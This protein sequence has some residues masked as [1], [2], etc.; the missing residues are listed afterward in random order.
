[1]VLPIVETSHLFSRRIVPTPPSGIL[2]PPNVDDL[3]FVPLPA[4]ELVSVIPPLA[5][6][7]GVRSFADLLEQLALAFGT[8]RVQPF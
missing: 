1:V 7:A 4:K 2:D 5:E 8:I 3:G 6:V